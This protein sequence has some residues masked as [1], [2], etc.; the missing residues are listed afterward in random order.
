MSS[1]ML[2]YINNHSHYFQY[3]LC[4]VYKF[5]EHLSLDVN[6]PQYEE[7]L[8][9]QE[10]IITSL[11]TSIRDVLLLLLLFSQYPL[12][13]R[14]FPIAATPETTKGEYRSHRQRSLDL[15]IMAQKKT[16][17]NRGR[18]LGHIQVLSDLYEDPNKRTEVDASE[19][20]SKVYSVSLVQVYQYV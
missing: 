11:V 12:I 7:F 17:V 8:S 20:A 13:E 1:I 15:Y 6:V 9:E 2:T 18:N 3:I 4:S 5:H 14:W 19:H 10:T 16:P